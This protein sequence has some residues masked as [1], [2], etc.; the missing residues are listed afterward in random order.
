[1]INVEHAKKIAFS[2]LDT[3][4]SKLQKLLFSFS[5]SSQLR[6]EIELGESKN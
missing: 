6:F 3:D 5:S 1:V 2:F 4:E